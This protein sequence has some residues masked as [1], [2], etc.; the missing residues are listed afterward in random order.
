LLGSSKD[1]PTKATKEKKRRKVGLQTMSSTPSSS[2]RRKPEEFHLPDGRKIIVA[3][4]EEAIALREKYAD[5]FEVQIEVVIHGSE[6][7]HGYLK[8]SRTH[9][10]KRRQ[11]LRERYGPAFDEWE[12][13]QAQLDSVSA[14]LDRLSDQNSGLS[15]SFSKFGYNALLRTY[16]EDSGNGGTASARASTL[17]GSSSTLTDWEDRNGGATIKLFKR[18]V[19][20]QYFHRGLLWRA[21]EETEV[22]SIELFFDLL[23]GESNGHLRE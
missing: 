13:V 14:Q 6:E 20:K 23:Y 19:I 11:D 18:P 15:S 10:E 3:L 17:D 2:K 22:M 12:S 4:P 16:G 7:H 8:E 21:S 5:R 1:W 9:H